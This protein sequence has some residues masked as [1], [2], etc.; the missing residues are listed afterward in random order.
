M[1]N[2]ERLAINFREFFAFNDNFN[3]TVSEFH[4]H[5]PFFRF[6]SYEDQDD[7]DEITFSLIRDIG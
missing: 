3:F 5:Y 6:S 7:F 4:I 2:E 1:M